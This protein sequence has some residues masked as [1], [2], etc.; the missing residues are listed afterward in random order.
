MTS[1]KR[2]DLRNCEI[3]I[4]IRLLLNGLVM[5]EEINKQKSLWDV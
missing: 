4:A 1:G 3:R 5:N 2:K